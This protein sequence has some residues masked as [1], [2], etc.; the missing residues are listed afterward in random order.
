MSIFA[1]KEFYQRLNLD[2]SQPAANEEAHDLMK[3]IDNIL[4]Q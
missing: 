3:H 1:N 4:E 2:T